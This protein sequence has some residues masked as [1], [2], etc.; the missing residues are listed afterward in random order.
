MHERKSESE[1]AQSCPTL[2]DP[3][4]CSLPGSSIHGIFQARVLEWGAIAF[5]IRLAGVLN[6]G[7]WERPQF[8]SYCQTVSGGD[9]PCSI[10]RRSAPGGQGTES[11]GTV[12]V[13]IKR[14]AVLGAQQENHKTH[15]R[16]M[17]MGLSRPGHK[18]TTTGRLPSCWPQ[19]T[20]SQEKKAYTTLG[21]CHQVT[22][23]VGC[24]PCSL[25]HIMLS[26]AHE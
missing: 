17:V 12:W 8:G 9:R 6:C 14:Q 21:D 24:P 19:G 16:V 2:R 23:Q 5:S 20:K 26:I 18:S 25:G 1:V 10:R 11:R 15:G 22:G 13:S 3:M 7:E 4:D